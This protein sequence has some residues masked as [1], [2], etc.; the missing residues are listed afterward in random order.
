MP[1]AQVQLQRI[2]IRVRAQRAQSLA[3]L[4]QVQ[5]SLGDSGWGACLRLFVHDMPSMPRANR[6]ELL[7]RHGRYRLS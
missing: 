7:A 2:P 4:C 1:N 6:G 3:I 5:R